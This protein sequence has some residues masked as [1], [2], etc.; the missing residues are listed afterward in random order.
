MANVTNLGKN[1]SGRWVPMGATTA[2]DG[3]PATPVVSESTAD[4][5]GNYPNTLYEAGSAAETTQADEAEI[6]ESGD[7]SMFNHHIIVNTMATDDCTVQISLDGTNWTGDVV[8]T[9]VAA[10]PLIASGELGIIASPYNKAFKIR[11][12]K[13][14]A[15]AENGSIRYAH[16]VT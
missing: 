5:R 2:A 3:S 7:V 9:G 14:G 16:A 1:S 11:V 4:W 8:I 12:L 6:Y 15:T 10:T 13:E